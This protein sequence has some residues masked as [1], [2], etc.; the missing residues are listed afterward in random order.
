MKNLL[1]CII[2]MYRKHISPLKRPSC[3]F[4]PTCSQ[5]AIEAIEKYGALKG[6]LISIKRILRCHPFNKGGYDPL[7]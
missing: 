1:I 5:Y 7:K 3:R 6:T 2:K 4:Y